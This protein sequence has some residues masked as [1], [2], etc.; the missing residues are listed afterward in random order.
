MTKLCFKD[1]P[2]DLWKEIDTMEK[3]KHKDL[4]KAKQLAR[5]AQNSGPWTLRLD[6]AL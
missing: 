6:G 4:R 5:A 3:V 2:R 1:R